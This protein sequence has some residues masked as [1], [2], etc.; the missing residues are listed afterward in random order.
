MEGG[1]PAWLYL[2]SQRM[3][4]STSSFVRFLRSAFWTYIGYT[5]ENSVMKIPC[6]AIVLV[7]FNAPVPQRRP[8]LRFRGL[9]L[10]GARL[11]IRDE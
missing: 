11:G 6:L 3:T 4:W 2:V 1:S 10:A 9:D 5:L 7:V 8:F